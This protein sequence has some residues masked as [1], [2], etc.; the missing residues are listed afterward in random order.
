MATPNPWNTPKGIKRPTSD[1]YQALTGTDSVIIPV[2]FGFL[3]E[4]TV[5]GT[6]YDISYTVAR[7]PA[8]AAASKFIY[9]KTGATAAETF[10][11]GAIVTAVKIDTRADAEIYGAQTPVT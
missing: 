1:F 8:A 11:L 7:D 6:D 10:P 4:F 3:S 2:D 5:Y 9:I